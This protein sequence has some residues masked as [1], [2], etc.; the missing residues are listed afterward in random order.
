MGLES[1]WTKSSVLPAGFWSHDI[2]LGPNWGQVQPEDTTESSPKDVAP[3][4]PGGSSWSSGSDSV[5]VC[6]C[7]CSSLL[8]AL[9]D[10]ILSLNRKLICS[11]WRVR[12]FWKTEERSVWS[13]LREVMGSDD[14]GGSENIWLDQNTSRVSWMSWKTGSRLK[15][16]HSWTQFQFSVSLK[17][18]RPLQVRSKPRPHHS[19]KL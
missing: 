13:K 11:C 3:D 14:A 19:L 6:F 10:L 9:W 2:L 17:L 18:Q 12:F 1:S 16:I 7:T 4:R 8:E 15:W 5:H